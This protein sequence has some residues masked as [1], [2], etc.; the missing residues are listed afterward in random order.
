[1]SEIMAEIGGLA[2]GDAYPT[3]LMGVINLS[4]ESFY[5]GSYAPD[6]DAIL[7]TAQSMMAMGASFVDLGARSTAPGVEPI[8]IDEEERRIS[9]PFELL[10]QQ[11]PHELLLSIDTQYGQVARVCYEIAN[12]YNRNII[13]NDVSCLRTD[14]D[15]QNFVIET[16]IPTILMASKHVPGDCLTMEEILHE[17]NVSINYL[18]I[19]GYPC[20]RIIV[21]PGIGHWVPEKVPSYDLA[22]INRLQELHALKLPVLVAISR[23]S[24]IGAVLDLP[25]PED[26]LQGT[27]A[28]TAIAVFNGAHIIRTHDVNAETVQ[29]IRMAQSI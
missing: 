7:S 14:T 13:L 25:H 21:D 6:D 15:L 20:E 11:M 1:M 28:A 23:K 18:V 9:G 19:N 16:Q 27:L 10:C 8:T 29:T 2:I 3:R 24:F 26:R 12:Q 5:K 17:L 4:A 22:I